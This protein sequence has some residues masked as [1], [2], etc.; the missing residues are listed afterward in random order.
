MGKLHVKGWGR[1]TNYLNGKV[2][3]QGLGVG[4]GKKCTQNQYSYTTKDPT[5]KDLVLTVNKHQHFAKSCR[6]RSDNCRFNFP[7]FPTV[8][9]V[10]SVPSKIICK[11]DDDPEEGAKNKK[12]E[13]IS[14]LQ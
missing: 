13:K 10:L 7:R 12:K 6:K 11:D 4:V 2:A 5:P 8:I 9:T 1:K 14:L 3:C